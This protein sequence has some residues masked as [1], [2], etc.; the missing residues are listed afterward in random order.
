MGSIAIMAVV[1]LAS[2]SAN[3]DFDNTNT[4]DLNTK[5]SVLSP[6]E[7]GTYLA[8][9]KNTRA[10]E[11]TRAS[12][13]DAP[14]MTTDLL[15]TMG[16]GVT[17][18]YTGSTKYED[19]KEPEAPNFMYNTEVSDR[20]G[21]GWTYTP[22]KYWPNGGQK[23][24]ATPVE[25]A[26]YLSF[27]AYAPYKDLSTTSTT[28]TTGITALSANTATG[29]PTVTYA[30]GATGADADLLWGTAGTNGTTTSGDSQA[31]TDLNKR[32][33]ALV[34]ANL[35]KMKVDGKVQFNFKHALAKFGGTGAGTDNKTSG[36]MVV[37]DIDN[38]SATTGGT[39]DADTKITVKSIKIESV[40]KGSD[41]NMTKEASIPTSG[42]LNLATGVWTTTGTN[43]KIDYEINSPKATATVTAPKG[44]TVQ[45][46]NE[47]IAEP[48]GDNIPWE[49]LPKGVTTTPQSVY[50]ETT[51]LLII[52]D[53]NDHVFRIT[54]DY[55]VRT[56]DEALSKKYTEVEQSFYKDL[57]LKT[58]SLNAKYNLLIHL[59]LTSV[60]FEANVSNWENTANGGA[61]DGSS[62]DTDPMVI[63]MPANV[64]SAK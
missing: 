48:T 40:I 27:F 22:I 64:A 5:E 11:S 7:F 61:T 29:D 45:T 53:G 21:K 3:S 23:G 57:T 10:G 37:A 8:Q 1:S 14:E 42:T 20:D 59:G 2:C 49:N 63:Y 12:A 24:D 51:P 36:L 56:K 52:P 38:G 58:V 55:I 16:F 15:K 9:S 17:A 25:A 4:T 35:S 6:V 54:I 26:Q 62:T 50:T 34:N 30:L 44:A 13:S 19:V 60:K 39:L 43:G 28:S 31:G 41:E 33:K 32:A 46:L 18:F 47:A